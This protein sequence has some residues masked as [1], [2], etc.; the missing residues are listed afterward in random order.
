ME[1]FEEAVV[2]PQGVEMME[3]EKKYFQNERK[4][5]MDP[6]EKQKLN[7]KINHRERRR[8]N[9]MKIQKMTE[10]FQKQFKNVDDLFIK[11][12]LKI[13][14]ILYLANK[15]EDGYEGDILGE[16]YRQ[17]PNAADPESGVDE[18]LFISA[19]HGD[20]FTDLY[21]AIKNEIT[22]DQLQR[23]ESRKEKRVERF[24]AL[25]DQLMDEIV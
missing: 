5:K 13:P 24:F 2:V 12:D 22:P 17:F 8:L 4:K 10:T 11:H 9:E 23:Y 18:P 16:F 6:L 3:M 1:D 19:E 14:K 25:K 21:A 20:G 15:A 7:E